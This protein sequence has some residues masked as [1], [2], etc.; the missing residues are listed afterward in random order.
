MFCAVVP[1]DGLALALKVRD[2]ASRAAVA[3]VECLLASLGRYGGPVG[4]VLHNRAGT[5]VG[6]VRVAGDGTVVGPH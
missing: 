2:G 6:E 4:E 5:P 3:A 1:D